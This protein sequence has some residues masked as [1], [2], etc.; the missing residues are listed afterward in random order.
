MKINTHYI[1][2]H[3]YQ[4]KGLY[5]PEHGYLWYFSLLSLQPLQTLLYY[6]RAE[7]AG[8]K[9]SS[10]AASSVTLGW[11]CATFELLQC[12]SKF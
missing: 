11:N 4:T 2:N 1:D 9:I 12:G 10:N 3:G 5:L 6:K 7:K 8:L